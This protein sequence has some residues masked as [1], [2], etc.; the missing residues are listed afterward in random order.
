[1][2]PATSFPDF[3]PPRV[4]AQQPPAQQQPPVPP[5]APPEAPRRSGWRIGLLALCVGLAALLAVLVAADRL[6]PRIVAGR[7]ESTL[8]A[9]L[10]T[11]QRPVVRIG[12]FPFLTQVAT[13]HYKRITMTAKDVPV[14][15]SSGE[16]SI[17]QL[18]GE[19]TDV[20]TGPTFRTI[21][22]GHFRG[23]ATVTYETLSEFLGSQIS[24]GGG[25]GGGRGYVDLSLG[26]SITV[27]GQPSI[28]P[29]T[30]ELFLNHPEFRIAG[31][32]LPGFATDRLSAKLF[33]IP[34]PELMPGVAATE[35]S[36]DRKG[37]TLVG[38]GTNVR[39]TH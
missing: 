24:Y 13:G 17:Q 4:E 36:A 25:A 1:M 12:G 18:R 26:A 7:I 16:L 9:A 15:G 20:R 3:D 22:I 34:L 39:L 23:S 27:T 2:A 31:R 10:E 32:L 19:L 5:P 11:E 33:R 14:A 38:S 6:A 37:M 21:T 35:V 29:S 28:D 8:Q 30:G